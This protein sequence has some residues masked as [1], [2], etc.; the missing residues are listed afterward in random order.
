MTCVAKISAT[1]MLALHARERVFSL[2]H[3]PSWLLLAFGAGMVNAIAFLACARFVTHV[4]GTVTRVGMDAAVLWL[5]ADYALVVGAFVIGAMGSVLAID[6]RHHR[7]KPPL[8]ALPLLVVAA[9]LTLVALLGRSG[10]FGQFG[11]AP[12][13]NGDFA[14]LA[15]LAFAM[16][17][18]NAAVATS[19]G[20]AVRT[21]HLT[22]PATDLGVGLATWFYSE[23]DTKQAALRGAA[24]RAGKLVAF[25]LGA[26]AAVP[27]SASLGYLAFVAPAATVLIATA[28]SFA[29]RPILSTKGD[30]V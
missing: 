11:G 4:T 26:W 3:A 2:R 17:L 5:A 28:S 10:L 14:L 13:Q 7:G 24:L 21:T 15:L 27:L 25:A 19:T 20:L 23:G 16:G 8:Y 29:P 1:P 9:T 12:E 30:I 6:G 22:G 18:Q